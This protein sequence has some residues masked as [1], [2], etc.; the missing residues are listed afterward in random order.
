MDR[1][2]VFPTQFL[3]MIETCGLE[4]FYGG[5]ISKTTLSKGFLRMEVYM[6]HTILIVDD[7][8]EIRSSLSFV[9]QDEGHDTL[10]ASNLNQA[11]GSSPM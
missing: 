6:S 7:D 5:I 1:L 3:Y 4:M 11:V 10:T 9:L 2:S 8:A